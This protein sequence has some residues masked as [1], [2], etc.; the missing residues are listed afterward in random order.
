M[1][2]ISRVTLAVLLVSAVSCGSVAGRGESGT[3]PAAPPPTDRPTTE[4]ISSRTAGTV[5][6]IDGAVSGVASPTEIW[7][8]R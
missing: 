8:P 7:A 4:G 2:V 1:P 5:L 6:A 3:A